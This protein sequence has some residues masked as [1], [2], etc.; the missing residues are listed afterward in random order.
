MEGEVNEMPSG[1]HQVLIHLPI[2]EIWN[3][4]NDMDNWAPLVPGYI[5][6]A[7]LNDR[8]SIWE[9][10]GDIGIVKKKICLLI[11]INEWEEPTKVSFELKGLNEKIAGNGYF[12]AE[13]V[14][15]N[16]T[17][18]IGFL[19]ILAE[20]A[21]GKVVNKILKTSIPQMAEELTKAI[22]GKLN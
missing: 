22:A 12:K 15:K 9:F 17:I 10:Y 14:N 5:T 18:I 21:L 16:K 3:F 19:D 8:Q 1:T 4:V 11:T 6:H 7:K 20:G 2:V 13:K